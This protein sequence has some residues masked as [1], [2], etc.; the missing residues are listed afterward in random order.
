[1]SQWNEWLKEVEQDMKKLKAAKRTKTIPEQET[2]YHEVDNAI[3]LTTVRKELIHPFSDNP[4]V[5]SWDER[6]GDVRTTTLIY[7][8]GTKVV[9]EKNLKTGITLARSMFKGYL[10]IPRHPVHPLKARILK[11]I[12][13]HDTEGEKVQ[14]IVLREDLFEEW[15]AAFSG[16]IEK[17]STGTHWQGFYLKGCN[18]FYK[19]LPNLKEDFYTF[20]SGDGSA[21]LTE[22]VLSKLSQEEI[23][24]RRM[25]EDLESVRLAGL[26]ALVKVP[27]GTTEYRIYKLQECYLS[28]GG[29]N[30]TYWNYVLQED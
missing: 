9:E 16:E 1:M 10:A 2:T 25:F 15:L 29:K 30:L 21:R 28:V 3:D 12:A 20:T 17:L 27:Y 11:A 24:T 22:A 13:Y 19:F 5:R 23:L 6:N 7:A 18:T 14:D 4:I 8:D 26:C